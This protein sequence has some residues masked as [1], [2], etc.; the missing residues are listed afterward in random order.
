MS[1][2]LKCCI[3]YPSHDEFQSNLR[4]T[5]YQLSP[6]VKQLSRGTHVYV[7]QQAISH[8]HSASPQDKGKYLQQM[9][10]FLHYGSDKNTIILCMHYYSY[11]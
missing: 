9:G 4:R 2:T 3:D 10:A 5:S 7:T 8:L 6:S 1:L 11:L